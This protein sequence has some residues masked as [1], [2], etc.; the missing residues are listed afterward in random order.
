MK[1]F[2]FNLESVHN[3]RE[4]R[5]E[6]EQ[7][8]YT[9]LRHEVTEAEVRLTELMEK[10]LAAMTRYVTAMDGGTPVHPVEMDLHS[11]H[12]TSLER[13]R[14]QT[15]N[16]IEEKQSACRNQ[17]VQLTAA[18]REVKVTEKLREK[19]KALHDRES[20]KHEQTALDE[21][22]SAKYARQTGEIKQ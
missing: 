21:I 12:I 3:V 20:A 22:T 5:E 14:K 10:R 9:R 6:K 2:E 17:A 15:E 19:K 7:A 1:K 13:L 4:L 16:E 8:V 18:A 11:K